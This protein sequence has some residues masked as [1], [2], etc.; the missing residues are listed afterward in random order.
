MMKN[1]K[2]MNIARINSGVAACLDH[3]KLS[4]IN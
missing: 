4:L 1:K 3:H 2:Y